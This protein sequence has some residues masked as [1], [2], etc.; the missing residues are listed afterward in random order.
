MDEFRCL[1]TLGAGFHAKVKLGQ[2]ADG[3]L[4]AIKKFKS[5]A[6][7]EVLKN[8][9][10]IMSKLNHPNIVNVIDVREKCLYRKKNGTTYECLAIIMDYADGGELFEFLARTGRFSAD[11]ARTLF[12]QLLD[13]LGHIHERGVAHRD[14]K[15]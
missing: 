11:I 3:R 1:K 2:A 13:G 9:L 15:P 12:L 6:S 5:Q 7:Y 4:V 14:L 10:G 8:E